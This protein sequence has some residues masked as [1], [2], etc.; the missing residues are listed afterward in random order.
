MGGPERKLAST[1]I[2]Y[3]V[4]TGIGWSPDGRW[5]AYTAQVASPAGDRVF[6]VSVDT[7]EIRELPHEPN[8]WAEADPLFSHDGRTIF[9]SC[10]HSANSIEIHSVP[11]AGGPPTVVV[12]AQNVMVGYALSAD[13]SRIVFSRFGAGGQTLFVA[14]VKDHSVKPIDGAEGVWP[15]ISPH[16]DQ[17]AYSTDTG[18]T[19]IWRRDVLHPEIPPTRILSS[20]RSENTGQYSPDGKHIAFESDRSGRWAVWMSDADGGNLVRVSKEIRGAE[21]PRWSPDGRRIAFDTAAET[22]SS[23]YVVDVADHVPRRL[24]SNVADIKM[25]SWSH[26]GKLIYFTAE[27]SK[28]HKIYRIPAEG[29]NAEEVASDPGA[30]RPIESPDGAHLYLASREVTPELNKIGLL[31]PQPGAATERVLRVRDCFAWDVMPGGIY[32]VPADSPKMARY[33]DF[34]SRR[35]T[36]VFSTDWGF[37]SGF[38]L[39]PDGRYLLYAAAGP[40]D[41][42]IMMMDRYR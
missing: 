2:P 26:D 15:T 40:E 6:L 17:L 34:A 4:A 28:G 10:V 9:Y 30:L 32:F 35:T 16:D 25:P 39:S 11:T 8:C 20:S 3:D 38:S 37:G 31:N 24:N 36:D 18:Q 41:S 14:S 27:V 1:G 29:G 13:D 33:F 19:S 23:I 42:D 7:L 21:T 5:I 22:P 12:P